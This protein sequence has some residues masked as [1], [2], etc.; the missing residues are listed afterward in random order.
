MRRLLTLSAAAGML[1]VGAGLSEAQDWFSD[2]FEDGVIDP[3][4][5][6]AAGDITES[7]GFLNLLREDPDDWIQ[8]VST[9]GGDYVIEM[10]VRL[11]YIVWNDMFHGI[12]IGPENGPFGLGVSFGYSM[13]GKLYMAQRNGS[14][15]TSYYYGPDGSNKQGQWLHWVIEKLGS[16]VSITVDGQ[17]VG[18]IPT[19]MVAEG[20]RVYLPGLYED[21]DGL[22][23]VG[24]T[25]STADNFSIAP[26]IG[27]APSTWASIKSL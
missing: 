23:H 5:W 27:L 21:G 15:G 17:P 7:G 22:P 26:P 20:S 2:D 18:G 16:Q 1:L 8:T 3:A 10:D 11:D 19:G 9:Y 24:Y 6:S 13:Y 4:H 14:G 25:C 12:A